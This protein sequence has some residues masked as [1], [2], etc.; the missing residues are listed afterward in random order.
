MTCKDGQNLLEGYL[1]GEL[2]L[3]KSL[4]IEQHLQHCPVCSLKYKNNRALQTAIRADALYYK[5]R[6]D[7]QKQIQASLHKE[8]SSKIQFVQGSR[9]QKSRPWLGLAA[10]L[11]VVFLLAWGIWRVMAVPN[12]HDGITQEVVASHI[13]S[14]QPN[15]LEDV[16]STDQHT[17][18]PWFSGKLDYSPQVEDLADKGFPLVGGRLDYVDNRAVA[19][20]VYQR[21]E[22]FIN[23][24][25]W[26]STSGSN[27]NSEPITLKGYHLI[28]WIKSGVTYWAVSDVNIP[29]L[30]EFV[31]LL[32]KQI[33]Q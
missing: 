20:L 7:L 23:L 2:D 22:H 24:F 13:R 12:G 31:Q 4:E 11:A 33:S 28:T 16:V 14:L 19:V 32:Q 9:L 1:D 30:Q 27:G 15:H 5:P 18:K 10:G 3:V 6:M 17:V 29:E 26:P 8:S 25:T 21:R